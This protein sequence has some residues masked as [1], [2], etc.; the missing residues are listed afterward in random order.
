MG[1]EQT[2]SDNVDACTT[3]IT[4]SYDPNEKEVYAENMSP[5]GAIDITGR[6]MYYTVHF[7]NTGTD[8]AFTITVRDTISNLLDLN[9]LELLTA[10]HA[11]TARILQD[12][13]L[14][15]TFNNILLVDSNKNEPL[16]HG[17]FNYAIHTKPGLVN[18]DNIANTAAIYFKHL[19]YQS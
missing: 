3:A 4:G 1:G 18:G 11:Y 17:Y 9:S 16:S 8:T 7:Q 10:S 13:T 14:E 6:K 15:L 12:R 19:I 2:P 5:S